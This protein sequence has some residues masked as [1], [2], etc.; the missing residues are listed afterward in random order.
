MKN[1]VL[2]LD[3][4]QRHNFLGFTFTKWCTG[5]EIYLDIMSLVVY[6]CSKLNEMK[7]TLTKTYY[8]IT[9]KTFNNNNNVICLGT[10]IEKIVLSTDSEDFKTYVYSVSDVEYDDFKEY[11]NSMSDEEFERSFSF[12][13]DE[14]FEN[15]H[16]ELEKEKKDKQYEELT[17][18]SQMLIS[19]EEYND[20]TKQMEN[21][22][23]RE[24]SVN[25]MEV[26]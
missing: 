4:S 2:E 7:N 12:Y 17:I 3:H 5:T 9:Q 22:P 26:S 21:I 8:L 16:E 6:L 15:F 1:D 25:E 11:Y 14:F 19:E 24:V 23:I 18:Y 13:D 10:F 20:L